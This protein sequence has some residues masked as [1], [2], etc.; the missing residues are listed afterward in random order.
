M[1]ATRCSQCKDRATIAIP[2][3]DDERLVCYTHY[4]EATRKRVKGARL[5][6][7]TFR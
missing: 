3:G 5:L 4:N 7:K 2:D 1:T 6:R